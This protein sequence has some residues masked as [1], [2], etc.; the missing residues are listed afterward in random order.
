[1]KPQW[2]DSILVNC[3]GSRTCFGAGWA[4][5]HAKQNRTAAQWVRRRDLIF[6]CCESAGQHDILFAI[7]PK[8][9]VHEAEA[10]DAAT[11]LR[12]RFMTCANPL[13]FLSFDGNDES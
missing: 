12:T 1:M 8:K 7:I 11:F 10:H 2:T 3:L 6:F 5:I 4:V 9:S 13:V